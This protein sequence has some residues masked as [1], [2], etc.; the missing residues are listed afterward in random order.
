MPGLP[1]SPRGDATTPDVDQHLRR[2]LR[3]LR[4]LV[5]HGV[6]NEGFPDGQAPEQYHFSLGLD[7]LDSD[8]E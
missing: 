7:S 1:A 6:Y 8:S 5:R 3:S 2:R 4:F